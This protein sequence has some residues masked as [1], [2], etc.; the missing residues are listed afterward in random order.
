MAQFRDLSE[1]LDQSL[2]L[3]VRG[4]EYEIPPID[5]ETGL[6]FTALFNAGV[7]AVQGKKTPG[8]T[9]TELDDVAERDLYRDA[10]GPVHD[11][12]LADGCTWPEIKHTALTA[13]VYWT[14]G[15]EAAEAYWASGGKASA[16]RKQPQDRKPATKRTASKRSPRTGAASTTRKRASTSGT[17]SRRS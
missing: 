5:G 3:P 11:Q 10:L 8:V 4:T 17:T 14:A 9:N 1:F 12:M 16:R 7:D 2:R 6:R 15:D 13:F